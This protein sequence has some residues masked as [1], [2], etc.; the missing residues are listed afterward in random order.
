MPAADH[1][2]TVRCQ[3]GAVSFPAPAAAPITVFHC[4]C[5]EC[6]KQS[7]SAFGTSAIFPSEGL[8]PLTPALAGKLRMYSRVTDSGNT[9]DG[10]FCST[11]GTRLFHRLVGK[12][13]TPRNT[14]SVKGGCVDGL[15]WDGA[16][17]IYM[18]SAVIEIPREWEQYDTLP[19]EMMP[20]P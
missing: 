18:R 6:Q 11:C 8:F 7:G 3:C 20:K 2:L 13:G 10:Y 17:H 9:M 19:P 4:H 5:T 16:R 15:N 1:P 14:V 12:D